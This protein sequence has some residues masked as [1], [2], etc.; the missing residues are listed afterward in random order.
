[1]GR[2][3]SN[4]GQCI[5]QIRVRLR[6]LFVRR[7]RLFKATNAL[8]F[9]SCLNLVTRKLHPHGISN[10]RLVY[11]P[12]R[13][14]A[15]CDLEFAERPG[16]VVLR[17]QLFPLGVVLVGSLYLRFSETMLG[18]RIK[19]MILGDLSVGRHRLLPFTF[20]SQPISPL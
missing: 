20:L 16:D 2:D 19:R 14:E 7:Q 6:S 8:Q 12:R 17:K 18:L 13:I 10:R 9:F 11:L 15:Q 1:L 3:L 5:S 4:A